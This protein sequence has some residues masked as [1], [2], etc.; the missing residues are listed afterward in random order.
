MNSTTET[1]PSGPVQSHIN[2]L[3]GPTGLPIFGNL[4]SLTPERAY[5]QLDAW[6]D[7]F[8]P[9]YKIKVPGRTV[10]VIADVE[11]KRRI[12]K[13]RPAGFRRLSK[14]EPIGKEMGVDGVF[15]VEGDTWLRQRHFVN[16]GLSKRQIDRYFPILLEG[17]KR[18]KKRW[19]AGANSGNRVDVKQYLLRFTID[20]TTQLA[21]GYNMNPLENETDEIQNHLER[22][23]PMIKR[24]LFLPVP[25]W[26]WFKLPADRKLDRALVEIKKVVKTAIQRGK[27]RIEE[28]P[29]LRDQP[30]N[31]LEALL[32]AEGEDGSLFTE[33]EIFANVFTI[34]LAGEDTASNGMAWMFYHL[35]T[36]PDIQTALQAE[37]D[38]VLGDDAGITRP[39]Q[40]MQMEYA[41]AVAY[42]SVRLKPL[43]PGQLLEAVHDT[44]VGG[45]EIPKGTNLFVLARHH[46]IDPQYFPDPHRYQP[47]RWLQGDA[48]RMN[49]LHPS[50][51]LFGAGPRVCPG[52]NLAVQEMVVALAMVARNFDLALPPDQKLTQEQEERLP[53]VKNLKIVFRKRSSKFVGA[54]RLQV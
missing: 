47:E 21:F 14:F 23:F 53:Q 51:M 29:S 52:R 27:K 38:R 37:A 35:A 13:D 18:L 20:V 54:R 4:F 5:W 40:I 48:S 31:F 42:E 39:E 33:H 49:R 15:F 22:V 2:D 26:R 46:H 44:E 34:L 8:G 10:V 41:M 43:S 28:N 25:Y 6:A 32:T 3:P 19:E 1:A 36:R 9:K 16:V 12:L 45:L 24:R 7:Q 11:T 17:A 30:R 50:A